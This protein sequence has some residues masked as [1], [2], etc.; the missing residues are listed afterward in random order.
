MHKKSTAVFI[1]L[2]LFCL[3][4][5][6]KKLGALAVVVSDDHNRDD[7]SDDGSNIE[8]HAQSEYAEQRNNNVCYLRRR[9]VVDR[10]LLE[11]GKL[12][13]DE[14]QKC[15]L[16]D[17]KKSE[18]YRAVYDSRILHAAESVYNAKDCQEEEHE[19]D[20][21][22]VPFHSVGG[23]CINSVVLRIQGV[24]RS[25]HCCFLRFPCL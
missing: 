8:F 4:S 9:E 7:I 5:V 24:I 23:L 10:I 14:D 18:E 19:P 2:R 12:E 20:Q 17:F 11:A 13:A 1:P 21:K 16:H 6:Y 15:A 25:F 22:I 3:I